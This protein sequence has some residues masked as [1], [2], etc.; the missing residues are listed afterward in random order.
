[1]AF[2]RSRERAGERAFG[3]RLAW[4]NVL[5]A[6]SLQW[7]PLE[8]LALVVV[9]VRDQPPEQERAAV[10]R[11]DAVTDLKRWRHQTAAATKEMACRRQQT[12]AASSLWCRGVPDLNRWRAGGSSRQRL[13]HL[14]GATRVTELPQPKR[15]R[16]GGSRQR[17]SSLSCREVTDQHEVEA[18]WDRV[19]LLDR[20]QRP[21][22]I[23]GLPLDRGVAAHRLVAVRPD[24]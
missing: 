24:H 21:G 15:W 23:V 10:D 2:H 4:L 18:R 8:E 20:D 3:Q 9:L 12:A 6:V 22:R 14:F 17:L 13:R 16:A 11:S 7:G 19:L 1:M 5:G